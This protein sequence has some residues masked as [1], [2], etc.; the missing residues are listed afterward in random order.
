METDGPRRNR[1]RE[2]NDTTATDAR[3]AKQLS[4]PAGG[5]AGGLPAVPE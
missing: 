4:G 1:Q 2:A 5:L 3:P